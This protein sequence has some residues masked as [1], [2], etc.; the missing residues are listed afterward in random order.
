MKRLQ[1]VSL[2]TSLS[3]LE[4][5]LINLRRCSSLIAISLMRI[6][7]SLFLHMRIILSLSNTP[8]TLHIFFNLLMLVFFNHESIITIR[9]YTMPFAISM[10]NTRL[11]HSFKILI[12]YK[13]KHLRNIQSR[14]HL[15]SLECSPLVSKQLGRRCVNI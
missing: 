6:L 1:Y 15:E 7:T 12:A 8:L 4:Q 14:M 10:L 3:M 9:Q 2:S 11:H 13:S 5:D